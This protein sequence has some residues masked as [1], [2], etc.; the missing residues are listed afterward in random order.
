[1]IK[2]L[3]PSQVTARHTSPTTTL[4]VKLLAEQLRQ[5]FQAMSAEPDSFDPEEH[6]YIVIVEPGDDVKTLETETGCPILTDWFRES[7]YGDEDFAPAFEWLDNQ[8]FCYAMGY[9]LNDSG[10][11]LLLIIPKLSGVDSEL[12]KMCRENADMHSA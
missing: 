5:H 9:I 1:M 7:T 10:Y 4:I 11:A 12:L 8:L 6:G 2:L 3:N